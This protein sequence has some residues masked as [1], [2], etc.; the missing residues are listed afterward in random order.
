MLMVMFVTMAKAGVEDLKRSHFDRVTNRR[1]AMVLDL[2]GTWV[3]IQWSDVVVGNFV[4]VFDREE[5]PADMILLDSSLADGGC[6]I[7]TSNIDGDT[8]LK[9][10]SQINGLR[11]LN[12]QEGGLLGLGGTMTFEEPNKH[13][14]TFEATINLDNSVDVHAVGP[15]NL[16]LRGAAL[17]YGILLVFACSLESLTRIHVHVLQKHILGSGCGCLHGA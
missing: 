4:K 9:I 2:Q 11:N 1:L 14:H 17:R 3:P 5:L 16:L 8:N 6:Y 7:E 13:I 10:R 15:G 12:F